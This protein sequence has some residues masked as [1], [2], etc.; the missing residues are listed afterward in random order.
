LINF[1]LKGNFGHK[2]SMFS[3][4]SLYFRISGKK[5]KSGA[6]NKPKQSDWLHYEHPGDDGT[7]HVL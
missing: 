7:Y 6:A 3:E 1:N 2:R 4:V 5:N